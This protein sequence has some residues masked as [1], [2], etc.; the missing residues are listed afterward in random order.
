MPITATYTAAQFKLAILGTALG[1]SVIVSRN[2]PGTLL[3]NGGAVAVTGGPA[4]VANTDLIDAEQCLPRLGQ[5][6]GKPDS[7]SGQWSGGCRH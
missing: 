4:T 3:V 2:A 5:P 6:R 1:E 7:A